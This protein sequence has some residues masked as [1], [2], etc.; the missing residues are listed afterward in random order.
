MYLS[1]LHTHR[2]G[3]GGG[4]LEREREREG[5]S[6]RA[7][8]RETVGESEAHACMSSCVCLVKMRNNTPASTMVERILTRVSMS[9]SSWL[10]SSSNINAE[11]S[12]DIFNN[13][14]SAHLMCAHLIHKLL[15]NYTNL[16]HNLHT[17]VVC[18]V[19]WC[20]CVPTEES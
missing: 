3:R 2:W 15:H 10:V 17:C 11:G 19:S 5:E 14:I 6:A 20:S 13:K 4:G 12:D 18:V 9:S 7:T 8:E 16:L 1:F